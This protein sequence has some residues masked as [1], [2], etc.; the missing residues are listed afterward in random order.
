M[1]IETS[2]YL[3]RIEA[4]QL[5]L[6]TQKLHNG[7]YN[8]IRKFKG[9]ILKHND[10]TYLVSFDSVSNCIF[11]ALKIQSNFKY[12]TPKFDDSIRKLSIGISKQTSNTNNARIT[13]KRICESIEDT[14]TITPEVKTDYYKE[15]R[16]SFINKENIRTLKE[17]DVIFL[18][19]LMNYVEQVWQDSNFSVKKFSKPLEYSYSQVYRKLKSLTGKNPTIFIKDYR[20]NKALMLI[21][22]K[23]DKITN[24]AQQCGFKSASYFSKSFKDKFKILPTKYI[25]QHT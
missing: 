13:A 23:K 20:L 16:N 4:Y 17:N 19:N 25:Q 10:N 24:I 7:I 22:N 1:V 8:A 9:N 14:I 18:N 11:C 3:H 21:H 2:D 6:F 15:H 12:I 5:N